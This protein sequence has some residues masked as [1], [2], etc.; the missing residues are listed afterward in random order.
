M[1]DQSI[2]VWICCFFVCVMLLAVVFGVGV[3][4]LDF[5]KVF[6]GSEMKDLCFSGFVGSVY[7]FF[8]FSMFETI[9]QIK[10]GE[11]WEEY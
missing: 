4:I 10:N 8:V 2:F 11:H 1:K 3:C 6:D 9:R 5:A 7:A